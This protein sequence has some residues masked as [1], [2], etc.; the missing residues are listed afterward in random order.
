MKSS[1]NVVRDA[2][3][4][5]FDILSY[6]V[7]NGV[8]TD[9]DMMAVLSLFRTGCGVKATVKDLARF[10]GQSEDNVRHIIHRNFMPAPERR[11][12]YDFASFSEHVPEKWHERSSL[13]AD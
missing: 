2:L 12:Y 6:K 7:R 1:V 5:L 4:D 11:V 10:Y 3:A 9:D 8:L 13:P